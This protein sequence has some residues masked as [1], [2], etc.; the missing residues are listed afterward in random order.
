MNETIDEDSGLVVE[1]SRAAQRLQRPD[2]ENEALR[3]IVTGAVDTVPGAE[4]A[5]VSLL[6]R[7]GGITSAAISDATVEEVDQLQAD[8][9]EGPCVTALWEQHTVIVDDLSAE[10]DRWPRFAPEAAA[11]RVASMLSFQLFTR[12]DSVGALNLYSGLPRS[13]GTESQLLGGLFAAH[14]ATALGG[15]RHVAQLHRALATRDVIGQAKGILMER[16]EV[17]ADTAFR[18]LARSAQDANMKLV[19]VA[20]W[21]TR[22]EASDERDA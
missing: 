10:T 4:H 17:D 15:A 9:R 18:L 1:L 13:F 11:L 5:G 19:A 16:F 7:D 8:Y 3:S 2:S 12:D 6:H 14:A 22:A 21:L 20:R